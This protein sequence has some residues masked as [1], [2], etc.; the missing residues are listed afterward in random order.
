MNNQPEYIPQEKVINKRNGVYVALEFDCDHRRNSLIQSKRKLLDYK[1]KMDLL[2]RIMGFEGNC[3]RKMELYSDFTK[4]TFKVALELAKASNDVIKCFKND[5]DIHSRYK[6]NAFNLH[7]LAKS[8]GA[9]YEDDSHLYIFKEIDPK[10]IHNA[11]E[12]FNFLS[13]TV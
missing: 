5:S 12:A 9:E 2:Q 8:M 7:V 11:L 10:I 1:N 4:I 6:N 3:S 13:L